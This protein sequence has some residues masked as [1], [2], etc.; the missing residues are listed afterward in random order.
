[1]EQALNLSSSSVTKKIRNIF[2]RYQIYWVTILIFLK[3]SKDNQQ[4]S[5]RNISEN[6][7]TLFPDN[8]RRSL[9]KHKMS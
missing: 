5:T 4:I 9:I 6:A 7:L 2:I 1:M 3:Q 8:K